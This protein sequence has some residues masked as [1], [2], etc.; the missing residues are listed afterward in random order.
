MWRLRAVFAT[1]R[2]CPGCRAISVVFPA[3]TSGPHHGPPANRVDR[4]RAVGRG[5]GPAR[6]KPRDSAEARM[7]SR[8]QL[9]A[10][11]Q[12]LSPKQ[13]SAPVFAPWPHGCGL[14]QYWARLSGF[15]QRGYL[16]VLH[17]VELWSAAAAIG[18][19][20]RRGSIVARRR[21]RTPVSRCPP[22][23][24]RC[25]GLS[26]CQRSR[27]VPLARLASCWSLACLGYDV[28]GIGHCSFVPSPLAFSPVD[29][30]LTVVTPSRRV[31]NR[32]DG[33]RTERALP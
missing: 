6:P 26:D 32:V 12:A 29:C 16:L 3:V 2:V 33:H 13:D 25:Y 11:W 28:S 5:E 21:D 23:R 19:L 7:H 22:P 24:G 10:L 8:G 14:T 30:P 1:G 17:P 18:T 9:D 15:P 4:V 27:T 31:R 20:C